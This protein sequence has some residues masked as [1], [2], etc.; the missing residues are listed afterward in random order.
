MSTHLVINC[1]LS[2]G[3]YKPVKEI[4]N[5]QHITQYIRKFYNLQIFKNF[6][7]IYTFVSQIIHFSIRYLIARKSIK[8][9]LEISGLSRNKYELINTHRCEFQNNG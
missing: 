2:M 4:Q 9:F 1:T 6:V 5:F 7:F 8:E 3:S